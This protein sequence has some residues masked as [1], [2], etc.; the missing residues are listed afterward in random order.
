[1]KVNREGERKEVSEKEGDF[2]LYTN[3]EEREATNGEIWE[4]KKLAKALGKSRSL[5]GLSWKG[6]TKD[7]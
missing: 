4:G 3:K 5:S 7:D 2:T 6:G 1:M